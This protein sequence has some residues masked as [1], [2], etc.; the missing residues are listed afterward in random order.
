MSGGA[1]RMELQ[2]RAGA[3]ARGYLKQNALPK[4]AEIPLSIGW[5]RGYRQAIRDV[6]LNNARLD[7]GDSSA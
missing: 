4:A 3:F 1:Y 5:V 2:R 6:E 7:M